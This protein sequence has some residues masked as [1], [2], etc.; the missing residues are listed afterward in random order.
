MTGDYMA[1]ITAT[2]DETTADAQFRITVK[3]RTAWGIAAV[4]VIVI[5]VCGVGF[6]FKKD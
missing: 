3:T 1:T 5:L 2:A 6:V 4:C